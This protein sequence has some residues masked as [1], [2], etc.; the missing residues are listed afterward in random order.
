MKGRAKTLA[1]GKAA[2]TEAVS[3][4]RA[5]QH[6]ELM[7]RCQ[8]VETKTAHALCHGDMW[9]VLPRVPTEQITTLTATKSG[10]WVL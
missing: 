8:G 9:S 6:F 5:L 2:I 10:V 1:E 4:G 3:S 7:L